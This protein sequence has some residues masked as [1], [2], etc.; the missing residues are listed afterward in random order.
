[1]KKYQVCAIGNAMVDYELEVTDEL[2][3]DHNVE[4][5]FM[6][7]VEED[8]QKELFDALGGHIKKKQ[9]GGSAANTMSTF[10]KLGG[11]GYYT[12]KVANDEDG[13]FYIQELINDGLDTNLDPSQLEEGNTGKCL[14][15]VTKDAERTMNTF[16]GITSNLSEEN[17]SEDSIKNA[18]YIY[19]EG[20]LVTSETGII[21]L[22]K[23]KEIAE[24]NNVKVALTFFDPAIVKYFG[25]QMSDLVGDYIDLI[26]CNEE[27]AML[28]T[29]KENLEEAI[30]AL[31][32]K[33]SQVAITQ[34]ENGA[35][36]INGDERVSID[37][38][39]IVPVDSTGAGDS[40]AGAFLYGI[41]NDLNLERSGKLASLVSANVVA[42]YGPRLEKSTL[43]AFK[44]TI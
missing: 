1:M 3:S 33:A 9:G 44:D 40:F 16:L 25:D 30:D 6:T 35:T 31:K 29:A 14:V 18:E 41:C 28:F 24:A 4:K 42:K 19:L 10:S 2:L 37:P 26:F 39:K 21:A 27:E 23:A 17:L 22:K 7:L 8:R 11:S 34:G 12:C 20:A 15:M 38:H 32:Q 13:Q 5:G 36:L 43:M